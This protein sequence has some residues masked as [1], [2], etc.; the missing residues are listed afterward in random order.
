LAAEFEEKQVGGVVA[1]I[2]FESAVAIPSN[3]WEHRSR[4]AGLF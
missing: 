3:P 4:A 2:K 1:V